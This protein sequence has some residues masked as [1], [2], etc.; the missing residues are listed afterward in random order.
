MC[1]RSTCNWS[2]YRS[3]SRRTGSKV[4]ARSASCRRRQ[5]SPPRCGTTTGCGARR[6]RCDRSSAPTTDR[7]RT[8]TARGLRFHVRSCA[9]RVTS[10]LNLSLATTLVLAACAG[11]GS[12]DTT[13]PVKQKITIGST[14]DP[15]SELMAEIYGQSLEKAE[16]RVA[17]KKPFATSAELM[18]AL[19]KG[20]VELT[21]MTTQGLINVL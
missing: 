2:R 8:S 11:S 18:A 20:D 4:S 17:R 7:C 5:Q 6:C 16:F 10:T 14:T 12:S 1:H 19:A 9:V 15:T 13:V 21:A 3:Q